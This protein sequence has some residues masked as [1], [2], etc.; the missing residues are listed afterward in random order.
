MIYKEQAILFMSRPGKVFSGQ[1]GTRRVSE[2]LV[3]TTDPYLLLLR[4]QWFTQD[5]MVNVLLILECL[6]SFSV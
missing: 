2:D 1:L 4:S 5:D 3:R 6:P